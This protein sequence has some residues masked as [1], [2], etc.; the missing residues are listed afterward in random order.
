M[1]GVEKVP[2]RMPAEWD[3]ALPGFSQWFTRFV[4]DVLSKA[5]VRN[6]IGSLAVVV[7]G[8]PSTPATISVENADA[9]IHLASRIFTSP[10][11]APIS[12]ESQVEAIKPFLRPFPALPRADDTQPV[13]ATQVFL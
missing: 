11:P 1:A 2:I 10:P 8:G 9:G 4:R 5:D 6:A 7:T 13:L 12:L 3:K